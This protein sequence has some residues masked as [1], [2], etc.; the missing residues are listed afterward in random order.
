LARN[1]HIKEAWLT[2]DDE[3]RADVIAEH[4]RARG[5]D[6]DTEAKNAAMDYSWTKLVRWLLE[7]KAREIEG[8][9]S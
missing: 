9:S 3:R 1:K 2:S 5:I 7:E 4:L 8:S 6:L